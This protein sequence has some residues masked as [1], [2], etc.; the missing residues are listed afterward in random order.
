MKTPKS[1][2]HYPRLDTVLMIEDAIKK[3]PDYPKKMQL[4]KSLPKKV[5]Y[6]TF[7]LVL[8]YLEDS[9]KIFITKSKQIMWVCADNPKLRKLLKNAVGADGKKLN[10]KW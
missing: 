10:L 5:Q 3:H 1:I 9:N 2:L 6:Q 8:N 7:Q 4:W